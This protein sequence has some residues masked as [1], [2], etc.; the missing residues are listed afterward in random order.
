[1][2]TSLRRHILI[3]ILPYGLDVY[4]ILLDILEK[5]VSNDHKLCIIHIVSV[6]WLKKKMVLSGHEEGVFWGLIIWLEV[7]S[8]CKTL[9]L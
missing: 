3:N 7:F 1:M 5:H 4:F 9:D 8:A 6:S 2:E